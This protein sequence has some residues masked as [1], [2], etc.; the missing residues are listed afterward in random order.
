MGFSKKD[1][2]NKFLRKYTEPFSLKEARK[3]L[4]TLGLPSSTSDAEA[5][6]FESPFVFA[7]EN[8]MFLTHAGA[9][10][11]EMFSIMPTDTEVSQGVF[12]PGDRC[13]PFADNDIITS[14]LRFYIN[15]T[16]IPTKVGVFDSDDAIDMFILFGEEYAPQYIAADPANR[17]IDMVSREFE[18]PNTV[19]LTGIDLDYLAKY[20]GYRKG[21]RFLCCVRDWDLGQIDIM[22]IHSGG[23]DFDK[24]EIGEKRLEW[25]ALLEKK[26][27]ESFEKEGPLS[28]IEEQIITVFFDNRM[29]LCVPYCGSIEEFL[30][31]YTKKI[32]FQYYGVETR[33]W[34]KGE[35]VPAFGKWN[36]N[37]PCFKLDFK[38]NE[39]FEDYVIGLIPD[40]VFDQLILDFLYQKGNKERSKNFAFESNDEKDFRKYL[41]K[42][43]NQDGFEVREDKI[44]KLTSRFIYRYS[45]I[46]E[47]YNWFRDQV[48]GDIRQRVLSLYSK[49]SFLIRKIDLIGESVLDFPAQEVIIIAQLYGHIYRMLEN[50]SKD[51]FVEAS[52]KALELSIEGMEW[53]FDEIRGVLE[54]S[55]AQEERSHFKIIKCAGKDVLSGTLKK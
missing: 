4:S 7:L 24:G 10:T 52:A 29:S 44:M 21:D 20:H 39:S 40:A 22:I 35:V 45:A 37:F 30:F 51:S 55:F 47:K 6:L 25:Y 26:M 27:L 54:D 18:L 53:N 46:K 50:I 43:I 1:V 2:A 31:K 48:I 14:S 28:S 42:F 36:N 3:V 49:V 13:L 32:G 11:R 38:K 17:D 33:L 16:R 19:K 5:F 15:G 23:T 41:L 34:K 12:V 8:D 9:F